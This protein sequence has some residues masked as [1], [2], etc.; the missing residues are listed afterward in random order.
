MGKVEKLSE[1][2]LMIVLFPGANHSEVIETLQIPWPAGTTHLLLQNEI[3]LRST[4]KALHSAENITTIFNPSPML[5][6]EDII[7]F[8]WDKVDWLIVN[9]LEARTLLASL[10]QKNAPDDVRDMLKEL[11]QQPPL[12]RTCIVCTLGA[13]GVLAAIPG[14]PTVFVPAARLEGPV[15]DTTGAGDTFAGYFVAELMLLGRQDVEEGEVIRL[16]EVATRAAA[17]CVERAGTVDSMPTAE[18]V[19]RR[20]GGSRR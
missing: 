7:K 10:A 1:E 18:E 17:M 4:L 3:S 13:N 9:Q 20:F 6:K 14:Q 16:L 11:A 2:Q 12:S 8:P 15:V 19:E 5:D